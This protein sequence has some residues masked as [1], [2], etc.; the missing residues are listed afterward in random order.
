MKSIAC[1]IY[2]SEHIKLTE[3]DRPQQFLWGYG[4]KRYLLSMKMYFSFKYERFNKIT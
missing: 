4:L 1:E 3:P 2:T